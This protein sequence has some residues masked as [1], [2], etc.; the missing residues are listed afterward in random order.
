MCKSGHFLDAFWGICGGRVFVAEV[1]NERCAA[2][3]VLPS[4]SNGVWVYGVGVRL[5]ACVDCMHWHLA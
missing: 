4:F 5:G 3:H 2:L 1:V